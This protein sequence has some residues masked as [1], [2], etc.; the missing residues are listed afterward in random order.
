M[1]VVKSWALREA[2][3]EIPNKS[4][5][6]VREFFRDYL[7]DYIDEIIKE[8]KRVAGPGRMVTKTVLREAIYIVDLS[9]ANN[10]QVEI[11]MLSPGQ[12]VGDNDS[13]RYKERDGHV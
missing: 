11:D 2:F 5:A 12:A 1:K 4:Y 9:R 10:S 3:R 7:D 13:R 8:C 6:E